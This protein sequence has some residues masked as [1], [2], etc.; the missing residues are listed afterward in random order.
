MIEDDAELTLH[1]VEE[2][3]IVGVQLELVRLD[4]AC[5][6]EPFNISRCF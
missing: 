4:V 6:S 5:K 3:M 1:K 2:E